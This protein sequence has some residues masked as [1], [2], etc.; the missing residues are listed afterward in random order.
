MFFLGGVDI[1]NVIS[2]W[3]STLAARTPKKGFG[4]EDFC[5]NKNIQH[6]FH[7]EHGFLIL[8]IIHM[9]YIYYVHIHTECE[10]LLNENHQV[11]IRCQTG[12]TAD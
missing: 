10:V 6:A 3:D 7:I 1:I 9:L 5:I 12:G 2:Q 8:C 4:N 11:E